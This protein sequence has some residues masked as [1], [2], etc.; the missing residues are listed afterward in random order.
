MI[1]LRSN[2]TESK[3]SRFAHLPI[4]A[5][6]EV[7]R[8]RLALNNPIVSGQ[9][10]YLDQPLYDFY[11]VDVATALIKLVMFQVQI[12]QPYTAGGLAIT[13]K[14]IY[15]TNL[16]QGGML[17]APKKHLTKGVSVIPWAATHPTDLNA[18][19]SQVL[20]Q[21][22]IAEKTYRQALVAKCPAGGGPFFY[23]TP[24]GGLVAMLSGAANGW[25]D[26][27]NVANLTDEF[28][29]VPGLDPMPAIN[30]QLI[31]Q[32]Q[33]F[34]VI[35]DPTIT[36]FTVYTTQAAAGDDDTIGIGLL[37]HVYLEGILIRGVQ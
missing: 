22:N 29:Q 2:A 35:L 24:T 23:G 13:A 15:H 9:L 33:N 36:G 25:P 31:E 18:F 4:V 27:R 32:G 12:G 11:G 16:V 28:P 3:Y 14:T 20:L 21:F 7:G 8:P 37:A 17:D 19:I 10:E 30:G 5:E 34:N 1:Q 26:V 6:R